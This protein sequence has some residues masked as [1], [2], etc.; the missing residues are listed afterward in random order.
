MH[1]SR[2]II[3]A[4]AFAIT[5]SSVV[6]STLLPLK[7]DDLATRAESIVVA[8]VADVTPRF[9]DAHTLIVSDVSLAVDET[10]AGAS[11]S[12]LTV[13]EYGGRVG[14]V[15]LVV[16]GL[17]RFELGE[18]VVLFVCRDALGLART[19]GASQGR[20][21]VVEDAGGALRAVGMTGDGPVDE[22]LVSLKARVRSLRAG[23]GR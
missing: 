2:R 9:N 11:V 7:L 5:A 15:E 4:I 20:L 10:V 23:A 16:P 19:C 3:V 18:R 1:R 21:R 6:A 8:T 13:S 12:Y 14:D 22:P 17:P